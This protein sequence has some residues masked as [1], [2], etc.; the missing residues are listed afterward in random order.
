MSEI[1]LTQNQLRDISIINDV[2]EKLMPRLKTMTVDSIINE[3]TFINSIESTIPEKT[4]MDVHIDM[5]LGKG[6]QTISQYY[7]DMSNGYHGVLEAARKILPGQHAITESIET[8]KAYISSKLNEELM[9]ISPP[10]MSASADEI[11]TALTGG[12]MAPRKTGGWSVIPLLKDLWT[13]CTEGGSVIGIIQFIFDIIGFVGDFIYPGVGA[14][15]DIINAVIYFIRGKW[16]LGAISLIAAIIVGGGDILKLAK[17]AAHLATPIMVNLS[18]GSVSTAA[19]AVAKMGAKDSSMVMTLLRSMAAILPSTVSKAS[20]FIGAVFKNMGRVLGYIPGLGA[21]VKPIFDFL[22]SSLTNFGSKMNAFADNFKLMDKKLA[23]KSVNKVEQAMSTPGTIYKLSDD[24]KMLIA[25]KGDKE[26]ASISTEKL[27][28]SGLAEIRY[29]KIGDSILFT[30]ADSYVK[31][32]NTIDKLGRAKISTRFVSWLTSTIPKATVRSIKYLPF[33]LGKE[34]Y[35]IVTGKEWTG[36][37]GDAEWS[38]EEI[39][40]H[41][42][43][44]MNQ[45]T[46]DKF[47]S[48]K[49]E[50]GAAYVP[51]V[52]LDASNKEDYQHIVDYQNHYAKMLGEPSVMPVIVKNY[53][54][55][56]VDSEFNDFFEELTKGDITRG[57]KEDKI[58]HRGYD[59]SYQDEDSTSKSTDESIAPFSPTKVKS[60]SQFIK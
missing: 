59:I 57:S 14:A 1:S 2:V 38:R 46:E 10:S 34:I 25:K 6:K 39:E 16:M 48:K 36:K 40:G 53:D 9:A 51:Y 11:H 56:K 22:G 26:I 47:K 41:G 37:G 20:T 17:P 18:K 44:A 33:F 13:A 21:L 23:T 43:A 4:L 52:E 19:D 60:F 28:D 30:D 7:K 29:G 5:I 12:P 58:H 49:E 35:K 42:N 31:Y 15:F 8:F 54:K 32:L 27:L 50:T 24:G 55:N 3:A 45:Y